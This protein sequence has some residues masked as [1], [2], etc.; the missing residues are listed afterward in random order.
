[1]FYAQHFRKMV[2]KVV[3]ELATLGSVVMYFGTTKRLIHPLSSAFATVSAVISVTGI[4]SIHREYLLQ[5][6]DIGSG[7]TKSMLMCSKLLSGTANVSKSLFVC[8][9]ILHR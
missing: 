4:A 9:I 5:L 1:M 8:R 7:S 3:F 2:K 6:F